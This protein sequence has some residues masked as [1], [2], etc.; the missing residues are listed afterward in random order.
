MLAGW[1]AV[2]VH[3]GAAGEE[4]YYGGAYDGQARAKHLAY[5][6]A[7]LQQRFAGGSFDGAD[8]KD[9]IQNPL[10]DVLL[11]FA[12]G[13][14]DGQDRGREL[15]RASPLLSDSDG[16]Q[17]VD[18]WELVYVD[19]LAIL[20]GPGDHDGD[21]ATDLHELTAD[22][23]PTGSNSFF[24]ITSIEMTNAINVTFTCTDSRNYSLEHTT[25]LISGGWAPVAGQT[26]IPGEADGSMFLADTNAATFRAYRVRVTEP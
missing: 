11:R 2:A 14:Y 19:G 9:V 4:R 1:L 20:Y 26:N 25:S 18:W 6:H 3:A 17:L 23:I 5:A 22:T 15:D 24:R 13:G 10:A 8:H 16:D 7:D 21:G 12:G